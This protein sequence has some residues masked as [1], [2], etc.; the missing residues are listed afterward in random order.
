MSLLAQAIVP[1]HA[2][3]P[4]LPTPPSKEPAPESILI[5]SKPDPVSANWWA[6]LARCD[7]VACAVQPHPGESP[8]RASVDIAP[9]S[10]ARRALF[11]KASFPKVLDTI[12]ANADHADRLSLRIVCRRVA[13]HTDAA[14]YADLTVNT[15]GFHCANGKLPLINL[16]RRPDVAGAVRTLTIAD[17]WDDWT[18]LADVFP[19]LAPDVIRV[20]APCPLDVLGLQAPT[21]V[22]FA[23]VVPATTADWLRVHQLPLPLA[24]GDDIDDLAGPT[25]LIYTVRHGDPDLLLVAVPEN[26]SLPDSVQNLVIHIGP[27]PAPH[28]APMPEI[29]DR[30]HIDDG[31]HTYLKHVN[32]IRRSSDY[33][34]T[35]SPLTTIKGVE[36]LHAAKGHPCFLDRLASVIAANLRPGRMFTLVGPEAWDERWLCS[37]PGQRTI[38]Y[39]FFY[40]V[41]RHARR[42]HRWNGK[43]AERAVAEAI[44][45][46][47]E[48]EYRAEVGEE[49]WRLETVL[50]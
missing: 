13:E 23:D 39:R 18:V 37:T 46:I 14:L 29:F 8:R 26:W 6:E 22:V 12:I 35:S 28:P 24:T 17:E 25:R 42:H 4:M 3:V 36:W 33:G 27:H 19:G 40:T 41:V 7:G 49:T 31:A 30:A 34:L 11:S 43:F 1:E 2:T 5:A 45:L 21:T 15:T 10:A 48:D 50:E 16:W 38:T 47:S 32:S 9:R 44:R 20:P